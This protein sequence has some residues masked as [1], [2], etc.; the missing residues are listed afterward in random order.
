MGSNTYYFTLLLLIMM[1]MACNANKNKYKSVHS[2]SFID[3]LQTSLPNLITTKEGGL[4]LSWVKEINDSI[5]ELKYSLLT[6]KKWDKPIKIAEGKNWFVNWADYPAIS[7]NNGTV[8]THFLKKSA[9][10]TYAYDIKLNISREENDWKTNLPLHNDN[11]K[12]EHG[13][14]TMLPY[15]DNF[16]LTWLDGRNTGNEKNQSSDGHSGHGGA[17]TVRCAEITPEGKIV[18]EQLLDHKTCSCCQTTAVIT[19]NGPIVLYRDRTDNEVR[20]IA[21]TR[22]VNGKWITPQP[23]Y[24]DQWMIKGCPVNGPKVDAIENTIAAA[25]FT[26][27]ND[28]P[29]VK[30]IFSE[31][32]GAN[33]LPPIVVD[34]NDPLGRVDIELIDNDNAIVSWIAVENEKSYLK[35]MKVHKS[36]SKSSPITITEID[37]SRKSGF[38][39]ME[40]SGR[41]MYFAWTLIEA[42][43]S[44][45]RTAYVLMDAF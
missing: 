40:R 45:I 43:K 35:A 21:I 18:N 19:K 41:K 10:K 34:E 38:P 14:V 24:N 4:M 27:V 17:M 11:T 9:K 6:N 31:D 2:I 7:E 30:V 32:G 23:I 28:K 29:E 26:A 42:E 16:F 36:G 22:Y 13:F 33:F 12:T 3:T 20:D 8:L 44:S 25:W 37:S 15:K 1:L 5:T 39:Q